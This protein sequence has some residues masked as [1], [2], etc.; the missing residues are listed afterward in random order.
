MWHRVE[1][2][3]YMSVWTAVSE[4]YIFT[5]RPTRIKRKKAI[6]LVSNVQATGMRFY[7]R[8]WAHNYLQF[9]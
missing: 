8:A 2:I 6:I 4:S 3:A 9:H 7:Y 5:S 1:L